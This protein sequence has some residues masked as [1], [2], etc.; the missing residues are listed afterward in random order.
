M[1]ARRRVCLIAPMLTPAVV[2][3][4]VACSGRG[5]DK[6]G[7]T[8]QPSPVVLTLASTQPYLPDQLEKLPE[9][10]A[11]RSGGTLK[12]D[13]KPYW[14]GTELNGEASLIEDVQAGRFDVAWVRASAFDLAGV[15]SFQPLVAP[16]LVDSYDLEG[17]VFDAG[18]HSGCSRPSTRLGL[19]GIGVV[20]GVLNRIMGVAHP[21]AKR[22]DFEG[23][24]IGTS[25]GKL[26]EDT[27]LALG[28]TPK[29][30]ADGPRLDGLDGL[31][32][33][34]STIRGQGYY[35]AASAITAN[36]DLWPEP[37]AVFMNASRFA[38][39]TAGQQDALRRVVAG[40]V[41]PAL[42]ASRRDDASAASGLCDTPM[43]VVHATPRDVSGLE[44]AVEPVYVNLEAEAAN[45]AAFDEIT[46][47]KTDLAAPAESFE[48]DASQDPAEPS[49]ATPLDGVYEMTITSDEL[50]ASGDFVIPEN[51]GAY[52]LV[53]D[54]GRLAM[55]QQS[56]AACTWAYGTYVV[57]GDR[58]EMT[59]A[60]GGGISA[61]HAY[62]RPGEFFTYAWS[63]YRDELTLTVVPGKESPPGWTVKPWTRTGATPS[64]Q[65][66]NQH[67][68]PPPAALWPAG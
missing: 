62:N 16:F 59:Y 29:T 51:Y 4:M 20:P 1:D 42:A 32:H 55:T 37:L 49:A 50:A 34:L 14:R 53:F 30:V 36:I 26:A 54:R 57:N 9:E 21:F 5:T 66:L 35:N 8:K 44:A 45:R 18:I 19:T 64:V 31:D 38:R 56:E 47:L 48:C 33:G 60:D 63:L 24:V 43:S 52:I 22:T 11:E 28:A 25:G 12:I 2:L 40:H 3:A 17:K 7:G 65:A 13:F 27:L 46:A 67:C 41:T 61:Y 6:A 23:A 68:P 58:F 39:L 10:I 15:T